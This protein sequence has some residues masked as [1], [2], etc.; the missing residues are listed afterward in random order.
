MQKKEVN[1]LFDLNEKRDLIKLS[2]SRISS[3]DKDGPM[4]LIKR[5]VVQ[6]EGA[7]IGSLTDDLLNDI[8]N[9][10]QEF[11]KLYYTY[12]GTKPTATLG[13]LADKVLEKY[14]SLPPKDSV[15]LLIDENKFWSSTVKEDVLDKKYNTKEFWD[16]LKAQYASKDKTL[17][18]TSDIMWAQ[19]LVDTLLTHENSKHI[20]NNDNEKINQVNFKFEYDI[21]LLRGMLD[22]LS[23]DHKNKTVRMIDLKTGSNPVSEFVSSFIKW[24]YYIQEAV[25]TKAIKTILK[26]FK[27]EEYEVLPFQF[28]YISRYEKI[29]FLFE[30]GEKWHK[31]AL[32]G[33]KTSSGWE[34]KGFEELIQDIKWHHSNK[35]YDCSKTMYEANGFMKLN[36][37]FITIK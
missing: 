14:E 5:K 11:D 1:R 23:I 24:R 22:I 7:T 15:L 9:K 2:Y 6:N 21:F 13:K 35:I 18:T 25:Y 19:D 26:E 17:A 34:Y 36:D 16:Y 20:F 31:A 28:L 10:T 12:N 29:P 4:S 30:V 8:I 3:F 32:K 33:F 27:L 37:D